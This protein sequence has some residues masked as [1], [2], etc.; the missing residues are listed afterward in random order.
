MSATSRGMVPMGPYAL[1]LGTEQ[2]VGGRTSKRS[3]EVKTCALNGA[4]E[5]LA[6]IGRVE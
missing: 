1:Y 6:A 4:C 3:R 2:F 5:L